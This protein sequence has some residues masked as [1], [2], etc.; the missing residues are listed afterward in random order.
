MFV[1]EVLTALPDYST[2]IHSESG[3]L[4]WSNTR[5][6]P[7]EIGADVHVS[8]N[9]IGCCKV[10]SYASYLG[11]LG[12]MVTPYDPPKWWLDQ[13]GSEKP[14]RSSLIFGAEIKTVSQ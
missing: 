4:K 10:V 6:M 1:L 9:Q 14:Y 12:L 11:Y 8:I 3:M 7:P 2:D 13:N 5:I